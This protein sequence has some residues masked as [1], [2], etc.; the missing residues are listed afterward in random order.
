MSVVSVVMTWCCADCAPATLFCYATMKDPSRLTNIRPQH[1]MWITQGTVNLALTEDTSHLPV[2]ET[3]LPG[4]EPVT[5]QIVPKKLFTL[6]L[7]ARNHVLHHHSFLKP[8]LM[9]SG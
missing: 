6:S 1:R 8:N 5:F 3:P 7:A 9:T 4:F 2:H